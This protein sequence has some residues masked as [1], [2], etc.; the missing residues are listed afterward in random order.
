MTDND[1]LKHTYDK[2]IVCPICENKFKV[3]IVKVNS[4]RITSKD[5]D[6]FIR[7]SVVNP[8]F[9]DV[10]MCNH[11]GYSSM[12]ADFPKIKSFQKELVLDGITKKW[13]PRVYPESLTVD[14]AIERYKLALVTSMIIEK[15]NSTK[16]MILLKLA[17]MYRLKKDVEKEMAFLK[18]SITAFLDA[19]SMEDFPIYGMQRDSISYLIGELYRRTNNEK[20]AL[21]WYSK[22]FSTVGASQKLK[23]LAR[24]GKDS[25]KNNMI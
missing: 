2:E 19:Y 11:C 5:S 9:Y 8:Y 3:K 7:Y 22:V 4:P 24:N 15:P 14:N 25:L 13:T 1:V 23:D 20:E 12:K 6:F 17:W 18:Q 21:T 10:W 16:A